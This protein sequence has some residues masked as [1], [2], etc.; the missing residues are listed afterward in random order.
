MLFVHLSCMTNAANGKT[1]GL[2]QTLQ[3]LD[4][5]LKLP[6]NDA[7]TISGGTINFPPNIDRKRVEYAHIILR[8]RQLLGLS[9]A[10]DTN[11]LLSAE[12]EAFKALQKEPKTA[13]SHA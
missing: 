4:Q 6:S 9:T 1:P 12:L 2:L 5:L 8:A 7:I 3:Q 11:G 10:V 13:G